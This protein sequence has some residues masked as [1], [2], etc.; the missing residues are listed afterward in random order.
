MPLIVSDLDCFSLFR[1]DEPTI[2]ATF[3]LAF[4]RAFVRDTSKSE[5]IAEPYP[6]VFSLLLLYLLQISEFNFN[7]SEPY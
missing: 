6:K 4:K 5:L 7:K 1:I 3:T 2:S